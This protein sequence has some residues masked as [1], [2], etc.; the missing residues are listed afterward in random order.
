MSLEQIEHGRHRHRSGAVRDHEEHPLAVE[1]Q[2]VQTVADHG[3]ESRRRQ[4]TLV[5]TVADD[6]H[7]AV[8][9]KESSSAEP[10]A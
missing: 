8:Y 9:I 6:A 3:L 7:G 1:R 10:T 2:P 5:E 4:D